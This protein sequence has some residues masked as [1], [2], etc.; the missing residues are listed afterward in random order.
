[1]EY[2]ILSFLLG[3]VPTGYLLVLLSGKGDIRKFGSKNIGATNVLRYS[4]KI[5]GLI[6]LFLDIAKGFLPVYYY[7]Y[8]FVSS[9]NPMLLDNTYIMKI[10]AATILG[11]IFSPWL[12]F[13]GGKGVATTLGVLLA[14]LVYL[15]QTKVFFLILLVWVLVVFFSKYV[16]L[17]SVVSLVFLVF[18]SYFLFNHYF[19]FFLFITILVAYKHK[20]NFERIKNNKEHKIS[21]F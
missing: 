19:V 12:K 3:S 16:A 20:G 6:T 13:K 1:M 5:F 7:I 2:L 8:S 21:F 15:D 17:G 10:G 18:Y 4:G 9:G 11:H 14:M